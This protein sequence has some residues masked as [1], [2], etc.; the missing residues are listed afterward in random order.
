MLGGKPDVVYLSS[1]TGVILPVLKQLRQ[2]GYDGPVM[3]SSGVNPD[4][5]EAILGGDFATLMTDNYDCA[6]TLPT[7]SANPAATV[8]AD[9]YQ[10]AYGEYPQDLTMWAYDLP[11]VI[12]AAMTEAGSVTDREAILD[13]LKTVEVPDGTVSGWLPSEDGALFTD[14]DARTLS[15]VTVW[16]PKAKTI[17]SAMVFD[18]LGGKIGEPKVNDDPCAQA[19]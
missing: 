15:E 11:F 8:F 14:R 12:A 18:G 9:K 4:Q 5:A 2:A 10:A 3:H 1:V 19:K 6:G 16:C 7:T 13:A 17:A